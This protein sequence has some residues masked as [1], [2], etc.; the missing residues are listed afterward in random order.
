MSTRVTGFSLFAIAMLFCGFRILHDDGIV[1][2][3][4]KPLQAPYFQVKGCFCH[5]DSASERTR[6]WIEGPETL[7]A[8]QEALYTLSVAKDS[9]IAAGLDVAAFFGDLGIVD[10][11]GT[12][13]MRIDP[14]NPVDSLELTHTN[15]KLADGRDTISWPFYYR[16]PLAAG[17]VD[18]IYANGNSVDM[19]FDP[20][21]DYWNYAPNFLVHIVGSV[22]VNKQPG[23]KTF[24]L[25]QN[26]PNP[27]NPT[28][29]IRFTLPFSG[30]VSLSVFD[31][32]GRRVADLVNSNLP[33]GDHGVT[34]VAGS[35]G[36]A[37]SGVY[38]YRLTLQP[39][40]GLGAAPFVMSKKMLLLK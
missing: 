24:V 38:L 5:G 9:S 20:D 27:F 3:T 28:T 2:Q 26:Y 11:L 14:N 18:T 40:G 37:S 33:F 13:L 29:M 32:T 15:P 8:G 10:S 35:Y 22:G 25:Q 39:S 17:L 7:T 19:S 31:V 36:L 21:G 6:V 12:Q 4:K 23:A 16:A 34:F 30:W 1:G